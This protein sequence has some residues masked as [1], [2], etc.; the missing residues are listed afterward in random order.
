MSTIKS[1][2]KNRKN[3]RGLSGAVTALILVIAAVIISLVVVGFAFGLFGAFGGTPTVTQVGSG[4]MYSN[5]TV[6]LQLRSTGSVQIVSAQLVGTTYSANVITVNG[7]AGGTMS[8]TINNV[9]VQF[10][11]FTPQAGSTYTVSFALSDGTTV[12][13]SVVAQ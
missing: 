7:Q 12:E 6:T 9:T 3:R 13:A 4:T 2:A 8:A 1:L 10:N 5:G 11:G